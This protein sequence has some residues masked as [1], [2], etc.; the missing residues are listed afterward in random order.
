MIGSD[1]YGAT[2]LLGLSDAQIVDKV[3]RNIIRCEPSLKGVQVSSLPTSCY[4]IKS[5]GIHKSIG[6]G[7]EHGELLITPTCLLRLGDV[8]CFASGTLCMRASKV[9]RPE[10]RSVP[11]L[12]GKVLEIHDMQVVDSAVLK[13]P[14]A[15][16]HF[17][18]GSHAYMPEQT[19]SFPTSS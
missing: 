17:S 4:N 11:H 2:E 5:T 16:T 12:S 8:M 10:Q 19:T 14:R 7:A 6:F 3:V 1:F 9:L 18:P 15:V 13:F